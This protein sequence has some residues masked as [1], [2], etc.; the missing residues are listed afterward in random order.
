MPTGQDAPWEA[1]AT[2]SGVSS[3][4]GS[5]ART[6]TRQLPAPHT[7]PYFALPGAP[8]ALCFT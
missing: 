3:D 6:G 4:H 8:A 2:C 5:L 7:D 1:G